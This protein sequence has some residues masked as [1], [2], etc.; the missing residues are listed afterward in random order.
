MNQITALP[1][2]PN[3]KSDIGLLLLFQVQFDRDVNAL[4]DDEKGNRI[5]KTLTIHKRVGK[6]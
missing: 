2:T 4:P 6:R 5:S 3:S 1:K